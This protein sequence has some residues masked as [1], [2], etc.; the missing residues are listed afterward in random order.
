MTAVLSRIKDENGGAIFILKRGRRQPERRKNPGSPDD[1]GS[2]PLFSQ[3]M[4]FAIFSSKI[5]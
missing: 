2:T 3:G 1:Y 4:H 5:R